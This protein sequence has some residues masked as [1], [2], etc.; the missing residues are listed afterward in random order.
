M[1]GLAETVLSGVEIDE[2]G[3]EEVVR[4]D[5]EDDNSR[6][7]LK[8]VER[9]SLTGE[10]LYEVTVSAA[11]DH[12]LVEQPVNFESRLHS[13]LNQKSKPEKI[14]NMNKLMQAHGLVACIFGP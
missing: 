4:R 1:E 12:R 3:S 9:K 14:N 11:V 2:L 6:V 5:G 13:Y 10:V 8:R 7:K